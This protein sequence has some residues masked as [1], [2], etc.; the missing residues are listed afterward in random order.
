MHTALLFR[1]WTP[2]VTL[3]LH[4][5]P[6][7]TQAEREQLAARGVSVVE[8]EVTELVVADD[9][10]TGLRLASG[11]VVPCQ[12]VVV[13]PRFVARADVLV[14]LGLEVTEHTM[15]VGSYVAADA[16]GLTA[17]PGVWVAGNAADLTAW[18]IGAAA[19]GARAGAAINADLIAEETRQAVSAYRE[20]RSAASERVAA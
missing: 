18:V 19:A 8:G 3:F 5:T 14:A 6:E 9:R 17:V 15:G 16:M 4:T 7:P 20:Q 10:L 2:D 12:A 11:K 1:Q 13:G